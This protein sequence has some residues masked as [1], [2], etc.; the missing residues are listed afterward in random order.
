MVEGEILVVEDLKKYFKTAQ[1]V[2]RAVDGISFSIKEGET[3]GL[4]GESGSGKSTTAF[5]IMGVYEPTGGRIFF[6]GKPLIG[7]VKKRPLSL[8][9]DMQMVFQDPGSSLNPRKSIREI[10]ELPLKVHKLYRGKER[11]RAEEL[12]R[13][14][15]LPVEFLD[16]YPRAIGGGEKQLVAIARA[17]AT[18]PSFIALDEPTSALDVSMQA[19]IINTLLRI[20]KEL[21]LSYLFIT[22]NLSLMRNVASRVGIMYLG[23][24]LE[25]APAS[26]FFHKPLHPYT[27]MLLSSVP[28]ITEEEEK[29]KPKKIVSRGEIPSPV[30]VPPGCTFHPRCPECMEVCS[31]KE[32]VMIEIEPGH[33]V[34]C[35]LF[36][37]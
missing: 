25:V 36:N 22:H 14:V 2:V 3:F 8:K 29:L 13:M 11:E 27:K 1:G 12:L 33:T 19:K 6:K 10:I 5:T 37:S 18:E 17:L 15:G 34:K 21:N 24:L 9:K 30:N 16:R 23:K 7:G 4:V 28:V 26:E 35:H 31:K 20:Q 32:P